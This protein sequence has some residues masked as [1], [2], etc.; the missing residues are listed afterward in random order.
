MGN[1][2]ALEWCFLHSN[3][4]CYLYLIERRWKTTFLKFCDFSNQTTLFQWQVA[5]DNVAWGGNAGRNKRPEV[6]LTQEVLS[7]MLLCDVKALSW[8]GDEV[9]N[10]SAQTLSFHCLGEQRLFKWSLGAILSRY[11]NVSSSMSRKKPWQ[12][13][14]TVVVVV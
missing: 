13:T 3:R 12:I 2:K 6:Q 7:Y 5:T 14:E 10:Y 1:V 8:S 11:E 4:E 9:P